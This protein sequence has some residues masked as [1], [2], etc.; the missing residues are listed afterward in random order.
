MALGDTQLH[1]VDQFFNSA[2]ELINF[3]SG[4]RMPFF[5]VRDEKIG[6]NGGAASPAGTFKRDLNTILTNEIG[7]TLASNEFT[8]SAGSY[9]IMASAVARAVDNHKIYLRNSAGSVTFVTGRNTLSRSS[10][11]AE[12]YALLN[13]RFNL[14]ASTT[15]KIDHETA[16]AQAG[17]FALG[18]TAGADPQVYCDVMIWKIDKGIG[19]ANPDWEVIEQRTGISAATTEDFFWADGIYDEIEV[20]IHGLTVN[21][22]NQDVNLL[23]ST[24]GS[25]FHVGA[26]DYKWTIQN[27][28]DSPL[29]GIAGSIGT[30][31]RIQLGAA[32]GTAAD[33]HLDISLVLPNVSNTTRKKTCWWRWSGQLNDAQMNR[34]E[35]GGIL[36]AN[37][38][39][40][41]GFRLDGQGATTFD[42]DKV[43][44]RGRRL[45]PQ[46][47]LNAQD[48][49]VLDHKLLTANSATIDFTD[50]PVDAFDEFELTLKNVD[51]DT[52]ANNLD[53]RFSTDNGATFESGASD[54]HYGQWNMASETTHTTVQDSTAAF[55]RLGA[56]FGNTSVRLL[57]GTIWMGPL[58]GGSRKHARY[59]L[60]ALNDTGA[61][62][63]QVGA[64]AWVGTG[65]DGTTT[66]FRLLLAAGG[67]FTT[68]SEFTLRGRRKVT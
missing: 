18:S 22:D 2:G 21:T 59:F 45:S 60:S 38:N 31:A 1:G 54:Y 4:E 63:S 58:A 49:V 36:M 26:T 47:G 57:H 32:M 14:S 52:S 28:N 48:W 53:F 24:D 44:V 61:L 25:T 68:G 67:N 51:T 10:A 55:I 17:A 13:G 19:G 46:I 6:S 62:R 39:S 50:I 11:D 35:G 43:T 23:I 34:G 5:H 30:D 15:L 8:L 64:G 3:P 7:A 33:E 29:A 16:T 9:F 27:S 12:G 40:L 41:Q 65:S 37:N 56:N 66:A 20:T 42:A